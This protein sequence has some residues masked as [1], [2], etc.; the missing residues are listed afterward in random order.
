[1][2]TR[3]TPKLR[4]QRR[5][6]GPDAVMAFQ[7]RDELALNLPLGLPPWHTSPLDAVGECASEGDMG[8]E[9]WEEAVALRA[10]LLAL[11][12]EEE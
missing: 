10:Q 7:A 4:S 9:T 5:R 8:A 3:R 2:P 11:S 12:E 6:V 1:M